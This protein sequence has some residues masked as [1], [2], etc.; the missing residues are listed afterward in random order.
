MDAAV[1]YDKK[2]KFPLCED[3]YRSLD[4]CMERGIEEEPI[5]YP[6]RRLQDCRHIWKNFKQC[7][8]L[9]D[10]RFVEKIHQWEKDQFK[11]M[12][13]DERKLYLDDLEDRLSYAKYK[14]R[15]EL[16]YGQKVKADRDI[17]QYGMRKEL[18][19]NRVLNRENAPPKKLRNNDDKKAI[20][21]QESYGFR[22]D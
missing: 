14:F 20:M 15:T 18:L 17:V 11:R 1:F 10:K 21:H 5:M 6:Y 12:N 19:I 4:R 13:D 16:E 9:R 8:R 7:V 3:N 22:M 2:N